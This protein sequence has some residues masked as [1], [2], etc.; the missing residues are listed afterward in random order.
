MLQHAVDHAGP[1]EPGGHREPPRHRG[2]LEPAEL[3]HPPDIQLQ[4]R[5][6]GG[7]RIKAAPRT[8]GEITPQVR[9]SVLTGRALEP[10][11]IGG[12]LPAAHDRQGASLADEMGIGS[13]KCII[14]RQCALPVSAQST[15]PRSGRGRSGGSREYRWQTV[16]VTQAGLPELDMAR[17]RRW[18]QQRVPDHARSQ[19]TVECD[20]TPR[21]LTIV[22]C[23]PPWRADTGG[24]WTRLP[25]RPAA[26]DRDPAPASSGDRGRE[27]G[28]GRQDRLHADRGMSTSLMNPG[29]AAPR[30]RHDACRDPRRF[31]ECMPGAASRGRVQVILTA[32]L[33]TPH[34]T[35]PSTTR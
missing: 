26:I 30:L 34:G 14:H 1:V 10:A 28:H 11:Q 17:V 6:A 27:P 33:T 18:C 5:A 15:R 25:S 7:Q 2:G 35:G 31:P 21:H 16:R 22:E 3:L 29:T 8:P 12:E 19:V 23:R 9:L 20:V 32:W 24:Q 4:I 13:L